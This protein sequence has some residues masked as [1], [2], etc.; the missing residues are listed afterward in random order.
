MNTHIKKGSGTTNEVRWTQLQEALK[1][2]P[3]FVAVSD[4]FVLGSWKSIKDQFDFILKTGNPNILAQTNLSG[5]EG[6]ISEYN[7]NVRQILVGIAE[8]EANS[9]KAK[10]GAILSR[11]EDV[12]HRMAI[13]DRSKK[14]RRLVDAPGGYER[15][16]TPSDINSFD[17]MISTVAHAASVSST[18]PAVGA[19]EASLRPI[20]SLLN[21]KSER[22]YDALQ[23][24]SSRKLHVSDERIEAM[25]SLGTTA[26]VTVFCE[27]G[28][29]FGL[30]FL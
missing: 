27:P 8:E 7:S 16:N 10:K 12:A 25:E 13:A 2:N 1:E 29:Q 6:D 24:F 5:E 30:S 18:A 21:G 15:S 19:D 11:D 4:E 28:K 14:K 23:A 26:L 17:E 22:L 3:L 9:S 20:E